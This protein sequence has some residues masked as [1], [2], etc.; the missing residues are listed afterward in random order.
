MLLHILTIAFLLLSCATEQVRVEIN[1]EQ[2]L[3]HPPLSPFLQWLQ[4]NGV[5]I[6]PNIEI[7]DF[8]DMGRGIRA[9]QDIKSNVKLLSIPLSSN[10]IM[11]ELSVSGELQ[12]LLNQLDIDTSQPTHLMAIQL[13]YEKLEKGEKSFW[14]PYLETLPEEFTTTLYFTDEELEEFQDSKIKQ[15][16]KMRKQTVEKNFKLIFKQFEFTNVTNKE[17]WTFE[18]FKWALSVLWAKTYSVYDERVSQ[19]LP[20]L[21]PYGDL[22]NYHPEN[23]SVLSKTEE[24]ENSFV[25]YT[26]KDVKQGEQL[27]VPYSN[28]LNNIQLMMEYGFCVENNPNDVL[29]VDLKNAFQ[30]LQEER[31]LIPKKMVALHKHGLWGYTSILKLSLISRLEYLNPKLIKTL[32]IIVSDKD[33][34][35]MLRKWDGKQMIT[36]RNEREM[37]K[38]LRYR[39]EMHLKR[40]KTTIEED[41]KVLDDLSKEREYMVWTQFAKRWCAV[42]V[43]RNEKRIVKALMDQIDNKLNTL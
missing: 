8:P 29:E 43:R 11:S 27:F 17:R 16:S 36:V 7:Y 14:F 30:V 32:R 6:H 38:L 26:I 5:Y 3:H 22:F 40:Y 9:K 33:E 15:F 13:L 35:E 34:V 39:L 23:I 41:D 10:V 28:Q 1:S 42:I 20:A 31:T 37:L 21:V 18:Q 2:T 24:H 25:F 12:N 19:K 4:S